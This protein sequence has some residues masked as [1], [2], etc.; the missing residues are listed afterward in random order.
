MEN[1]RARNDAIERL[2]REA[3]GAFGGA[4]T[5]TCAAPEEV[6][7]WLEGGLSAAEAARL[8]GHA[9]SCPD[10]Q[11][12]VAAFART[13]PLH[14]AHAWARMR[15][16]GP[17]AAAAAL[18]L[19]VWLTRPDRLAV[20]DSTPESRVARLED[21]PAIE[22]TA[23]AA[24][25]REESAEGRLNLDR[26]ALPDQRSQR[27]RQGPPPPAVAS[28]SPEAAPNTERKVEKNEERA[29]A[30]APAAA[31]APPPLAEADQVASPPAPAERAR[32][33]AVAR[34][35]V[36][37]ATQARAT[38][39][40]RASADATSVSVVSPTGRWRCRVAPGSAIETSSDGGMTWALVG[41]S[42]PAAAGAVVGG[43][44]P[45]DGVCWLV[46]RGGL[47][48][49][50]RDGRA[51]ATRPPDAGDLT[52]AQAEDAS[53]ALVRGADGRAWRT[54]DAGRTWTAVPAER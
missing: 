53:A 27:E 29:K 39:V 9:A 8:E 16:A 22:P 15:W 5:G 18:F 31:A 44:S 7:A 28:P 26:Q 41:G 37:L 23:P 25:N 42:T 49:L 3:N 33:G 11:A 36:D 48:L 17:M 13:L 24:P 54:R 1:P 4:A 21:A 6:A 14:Q 2:L 50:V 46:G 43:T 30:L 20:S 32:V 38:S 34:G 45:S 10:C 19:G 12:L 35:T 52:T 40:F 47:V 51:T